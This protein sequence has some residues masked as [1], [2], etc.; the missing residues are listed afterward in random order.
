MLA[1]RVG[2]DELPERTG[3]GKE[4]IADTHDEQ[5]ERG[6][7]G[8]P[9]PQQER[10]D[11]DEQEAGKLADGDQVAVLRAV[12]ADDVA[13]EVRLDRLDDLEPDVEDERGEREEE[14]TAVDLFGG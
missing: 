12:H 8:Q 13:E 11:E 3:E 9:E 4:A 10:G 5:G 6:G 2:N 1:I 14:E 7:A